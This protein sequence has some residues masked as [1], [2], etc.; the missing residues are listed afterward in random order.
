MHATYARIEARVKKT[1]LQNTM[2][3][4]WN[5]KKIVKDKIRAIL[6]ITNVYINYII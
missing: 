4:T 2:L 3:I 6:Y 1:L 5:S